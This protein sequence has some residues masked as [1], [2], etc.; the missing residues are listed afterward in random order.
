MCSK[1]TKFFV[2]RFLMSFF[3]FSPINALVNNESIIPGHSL[4]KNKGV[5][6]RFPKIGANANI[7]AFHWN[8]PSNRSL[9]F[10][11]G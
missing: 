1:A 4:G 11:E 5:I 6:F 3:L 7:E 8:I 10:P 9:F 2:V